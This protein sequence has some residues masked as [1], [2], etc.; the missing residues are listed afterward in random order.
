MA[1]IP[2][3]L[4]EVRPV[5]SVHVIVTVVPATPEIGV[6]EVIPGPAETVKVL[7]LVPVPYRFE[8]VISPVVAPVGTTAV[9]NES[10]FKL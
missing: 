4:T 9:I 3:N 2:L 8:T 6:K 1:E 7:V 10:E 5:V